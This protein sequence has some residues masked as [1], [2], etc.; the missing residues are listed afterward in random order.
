MTDTPTPAAPGAM[1]MTEER[2]AA[3]MANQCHCSCGSEK[4]EVLAELTRLRAQAREIERERDIMQRGL[5]KLAMLG[6]GNSDGNRIA[7]ET[8]A[9]AI[10]F[11]TPQPA[12]TEGGRGS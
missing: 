9:K 6:G 11:V 8:L 3:I 7:Q 10:P 5:A 1:A 12:P 4:F 2:L